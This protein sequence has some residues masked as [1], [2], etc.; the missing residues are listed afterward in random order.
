MRDNKLSVVINK[1]VNEVFEFTINPVN[2]PSWI[3]G[4]VKEETNEREIRKGTKYRNVNQKGV[5]TAYTVVEFAKDKLFELKQDESSYHVKYTYEHLSS[6][7]T[8]LTYHEWV[9]SGELDE[10][11]EQ[12]VLEK[13][14]RVMEK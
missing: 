13:L 12:A 4:I 10:P 8:K 3:A 9:D 14:K 11:F 5:W 6:V 2:T 7:K 1:P